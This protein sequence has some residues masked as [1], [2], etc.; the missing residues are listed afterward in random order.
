MKKLFGAH[1]QRL[2][3]VDCDVLVGR[4]ERA[5]LNGGEVIPEEKVSY[6]EEDL[7]F[8]LRLILGG[9]GGG[10]D[11]LPGSGVGDEF[12]LL[13]LIINYII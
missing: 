11:L 1:D 6:E 12:H 2:E 7:H 4:Q 5:A 13:K 3:E 8:T 10:R 9:E